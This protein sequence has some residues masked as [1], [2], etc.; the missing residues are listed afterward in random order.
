VNV[1][2][3][4]NQDRLDIGL[5]LDPVAIDEPQLFIDCLTAALGRLVAAA[6][7]PAHRPTGPGAGNDA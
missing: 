6:S 3:F 2:A 5:A 1:A 7:D 4:G